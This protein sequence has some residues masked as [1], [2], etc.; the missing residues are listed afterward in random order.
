VSGVKYAVAP[1]VAGGNYGQERAALGPDGHHHFSNIIPLGHHRRSQYRPGDGLYVAERPLDEW[2][3]GG[4]AA[5]T[6]ALLD[7]A[8]RQPE[9]RQTEADKDKAWWEAG[10]K[11]RRRS[12]TSKQRKIQT[13][14]GE[15]ENSNGMV[16]QK[17]SESMGV[18]EIPFLSTTGVRTWS[19][20]QESAVPRARSYIGYEEMRSVGEETHRRKRW[21]SKKKKQ[22]P[23]PTGEVQVPRVRSNLFSTI[24]SPYSFDCPEISKH[25]IFHPFHICLQTTKTRLKK[26]TPTMR[27]IRVS[28]IAPTQFT[29]PLYLTCGPLLRYC[30]LRRQTGPPRPGQSTPTHHEVW[31]GSVMIVTKD[32]DSSYEVAPTLRLF[33][34]PVN[35]LPPPPAQVDGEAG[36][37]AAEYIDPLAGLPKVGRDGRTLYVR[38]VDTLDEGIDFSPD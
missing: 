22:S 7:L 15:H 26:L 10:N 5:L 31:R 14:D 30:G 11:G 18:D 19:K 3:T 8:V 24:L 32:S 1:E 9:V 12:S 2:K 4:T 21:S 13:Y 16:S 35:L 27:V 28:T 37:L 34:Q 38:P 17:L 36:E 25:N 20:I 6:G 29:P 23:L 33:A